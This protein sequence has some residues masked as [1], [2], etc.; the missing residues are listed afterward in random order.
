MKHLHCIRLVPVAALL[1]LPVA[2]RAQ[3]PAVA[4]AGETYTVFLRSRPIGQESVAVIEQPDGWLIRGNNRLGPPLDVVTRMAEI[5]YDSQWRP[6][7]LL[8]T[9]TTRGQETSVKSTFGNGQ[10]VTEISVAGTPSTKTDPVA[11]DALVLPNAFLGSYAALAR[12]LVGQ[13]QG[14]MFRAYI[15]PQGE[16]PMRLDGVSAERIETPREVIAATRYALVVANPPPGGDMQL[17]IWSTAHGDLLRMSV[18]AQML[19]VAREDIASAATRTTSF[20]VPGDETIRIPAAGFGI[21]ASITKPANAT[22]PLPGIILVGG[23]GP[24]DRDGFVAGIPVLGEM[25][26]ALVDAGFVVVR[27]DKRGVGQSGGRAETTTISDYA[28]DVRAIVTWL[29]KQRKDVDKGRIGVVGHSEGAWVAMLAAA[30]DKRVAAVTL[31]AGSSTTGSELILEQQRHLLDRLKAT[32]ADKQAKIALQQQIN[33]AVVK[34]T[35]WD[36]IAPEVRPGCR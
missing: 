11:D 18:P 4:D 26:A 1:A 14:A 6:T 15:A 8:L 17:N 28:D 30:R 35:G 31:I 34:G 9:G 19:D 3:Q 24:L 36:G 20:S 16:V 29:E 32:E 33:A 5:F 21:G 10:A 25:A 27:Y 12:R 7:R 23:S 2:P 13:S 22:A